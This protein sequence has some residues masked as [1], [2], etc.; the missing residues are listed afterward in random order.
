MNDDTYNVKFIEEK[1]DVEITDKPPM[2]V[3]ALVFGILMELA[4]FA[5]IFG[6][7]WY[8]FT[9]KIHLM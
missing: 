8:V 6:L 3:A 5:W 1:Q 7:T 4:C 9:R 2:T